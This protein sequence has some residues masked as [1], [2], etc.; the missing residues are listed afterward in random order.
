MLG[1]RRTRDDHLLN[2]LFDQANLLRAEALAFARGHMDVGFGAEEF[3]EIAVLGMSRDDGRAAFPAA[4]D[5]LHGTQVEPAFG[6]GW[7]MTF[8]AM[9]LEQG[10]DVRAPQR[11]TA[12]GSEREEGQQNRGATKQIPAEPR[13]KGCFA[14]FS[15]NESSQPEFAR[16][17]KHG[18]L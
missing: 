14:V 13:R 9:F 7:V 10:F 6:F 1:Q 12:R 8:G 11:V 18:S 16:F 15:D 17:F 5:G 4:E 2:P 3:V